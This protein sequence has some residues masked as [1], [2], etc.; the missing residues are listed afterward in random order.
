[1]VTEKLKKLHEY[2]KIGPSRSRVEKVD[3]SESEYSGSYVD[4]KIRR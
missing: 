3:A 4:F 2:L 1:V